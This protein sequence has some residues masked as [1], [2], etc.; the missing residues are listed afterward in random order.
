M[1]IFEAWALLQFAVIIVVA[2]IAIW[3]GYVKLSILLQSI[4]ESGMDWMER[5]KRG[6]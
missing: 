2:I 4:T 6:V 1:N 5:R 3:R